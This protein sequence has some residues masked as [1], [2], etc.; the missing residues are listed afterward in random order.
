MEVLPQVLSQ[1][2]YLDHGKNLDNKKGL[3]KIKVVGGR[4]YEMIIPNWL[5]TTPKEYLIYLINMY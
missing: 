2:Y 1:S 3:R 4:D 5:Q